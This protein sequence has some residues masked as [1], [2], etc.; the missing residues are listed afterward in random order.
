MEPSEDRVKFHCK[1]KATRWTTLSYS[2]GHKELSPGC[3]REFHVSDAVPINTSQEAADKIRQFSLLDHGEDP[4]VIDAG[5]GG[6]K[7]RQ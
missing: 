1:K 6:S 2:P 3:S 5:L 4:G 7:V